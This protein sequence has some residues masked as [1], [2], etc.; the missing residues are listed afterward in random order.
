MEEKTFFKNSKGENLCGLL[1]V[2]GKDKIAIL[3]HGHSSGKN[4][5]S[6]KTLVPILNAKGVS[7]FRFDF[8]GNTVMGKAMVSL[9]NR[10]FPKVLTIH[11]RRLNL[12]K[13]KVLKK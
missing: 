12:L 1:S 8:Y 11:C 3:C 7:T 9:K 13:T 5:P 6:F 4:S 10:I 2:I